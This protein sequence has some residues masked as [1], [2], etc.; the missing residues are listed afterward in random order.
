M[1]P[2]FRKLLLLEEKFFINQCIATS[3]GSLTL[4]WG[5]PAVWILAGI[6]RCKPLGSTYRVHMTAIRSFYYFFSAEMRK[7]SS[8]SGY[9][10]APIAL[11]RYVLVCKPFQAEQILTKKNKL[12]VSFL[13]TLLICVAS[14]RH[15]V[16]HE[17][18]FTYFRGKLCYDWKIEEIC[19]AVIFFIVP[20]AATS[21]LY[22]FVGVKLA[23]SRSHRDRNRDLGTAFLL[24]CVLWIVLW[25]PKIVATLIDSFELLE[26]PRY[27]LNGALKVAIGIKF[28]DSELY[29]LNPFINPMI[30]I[31]VVRGF[32][33]PSRK[34]C[35]KS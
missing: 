24:S 31:F 10:I 2:Y 11:E 26:N 32:Q 8:F 7:R 15:F 27:T 16:C 3:K 29:A 33:K 20:A 28:V 17:L 18:A 34:I 4:K 1:V 12:A 6:P 25:I 35:K 5:L 21:V 13:F 19:E 23:D 14:M 22:F 30:F 9:C